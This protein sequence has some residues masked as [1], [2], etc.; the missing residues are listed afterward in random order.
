ME[1]KINKWFLKNEG[2]SYKEFCNIYNN[3]ENILENLSFIEFP[4][5]MIKY[6]QEKAFGNLLKVMPD[7]LKKFLEK[8]NVLNEYLI[9]CS[10]QKDKNY[11]S[12][13]NNNS[14]SSIIAAFGWDRPIN[15]CNLHEKWLR[16]EKIR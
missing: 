12:L 6:F 13:W 9:R 15:W 10:K 8:E 16:Y 2:I 5:W 7:N 4:D 14:E 11:K 1:E 3:G